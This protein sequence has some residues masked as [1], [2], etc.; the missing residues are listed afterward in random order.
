MKRTGIA[1]GL[2]LLMLCAGCGSGLRPTL[3]SPTPTGAV[4]P[5]DPKT[6]LLGTPVSNETSTPAVLPRPNET[7]TAPAL[8]ASGTPSVMIGDAVFAAELAITP[9]ER[10]KG[11]SGRESLEPRTGMLFIFEDREA[12]SFWMREMLFPL[13]FVWISEDCHVVEITSDVPFPE[14]DTETSS[15]PTYSPSVP[16]AYNFEINAGEANELGIGVGDAVRFTG[17]PD[18]AGDTC[19]R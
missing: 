1:L 11:L 2:L 5:T 15:L 6:V 16:A 10:V 19:E 4:L 8:P 14:P 17:I 12:S 9:A 18:D 7:S 3:L 13:D